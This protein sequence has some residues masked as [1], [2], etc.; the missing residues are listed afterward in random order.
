MIDSIK[1]CGV[2]FQSFPKRQFFLRNGIGTYCIPIIYPV[3]E[4]SIMCPESDQFLG[5]SM[6]VKI[7]FIL[8]VYNFYIWRIKTV[9][10]RV[11]NYKQITFLRLGFPG[12]FRKL[13]FGLKTV[14]NCTEGQE[15]IVSTVLLNTP[16]FPGNCYSLIN[17][18]VS[19][20]NYLYNQKCL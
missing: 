1:T 17:S 14:L 18:R 12:H 15:Y 19:S 16:I 9:I 10:L 7:D 13:L 5:P 4:R 8:F 20:K 2:F 6:L 3:T 11:Q